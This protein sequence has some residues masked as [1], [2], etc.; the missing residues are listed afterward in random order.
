MASEE[1]VKT[2]RAA[3]ELWHRSM[4]VA[5]TTR[6]LEAYL[7]SFALSTAMD[8]PFLAQADIRTLID[9]LQELAARYELRRLP[10]RLDPERN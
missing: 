9:E 4:Q 8:A 5:H 10:A 3:H 2:Y 6:D 7:I 1:T